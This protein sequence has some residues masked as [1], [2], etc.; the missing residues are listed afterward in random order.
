M[1]HTDRSSPRARRHQ[2]VVR[3]SHQI[4]LAAAAAC[5]SLLLGDRPAHARALPPAM[6]KPAWKHE[7]QT[8]G[9]ECFDASLAHSPDGGV[10]NNT[11]FTHWAVPAGT[12]PLAG[13]P[14]IV[15]F[16]VMGFYP[17][18]GDNSTCGDGWR[19]HYGPTPPPPSPFCAGILAQIKANCSAAKETGNSTIC[20]RCTSTDEYDHRFGNTAACRSHGYPP[21]SSFDEDLRSF[22]PPPPAPP[23]HHRNGLR[24]SSIHPFAKPDDVLSPEFDRNRSWA[25]PPRGGDGGFDGHAGLLW[26][27]RVRQYTLANGFAWVILNPYMPD[28]W[29]WDTESDWENGLDQ[30]FLKKFFRDMRSGAFPANRTGPITS[31][32]I[33]TVSLLAVASRERADNVRL[34]AAQVRPPGPGRCSMP[35]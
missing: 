22:C 19:P 3:G 11:R 27:Q 8:T 10:Q 24:H 15:T 18:Q 12:P 23:G 13:W 7:I 30:P 20:R 9:A 28:S 16:E 2:V 17:V 21:K 26:L 14:V 25:G 5:C 35:I 6:V 1:S 34:R 32:P 29:D 31:P 33:Q 4:A